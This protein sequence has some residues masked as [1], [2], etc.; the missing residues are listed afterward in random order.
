[1]RMEHRCIHRPSGRK[2]WNSQ[3]SGWFWLAKL[4]SNPAPYTRWGITSPDFARIVCTGAYTQIVMQKPPKR[5][6]LSYTRRISCFMQKF[7]PSTFRV[8]VTSTGMKPPLPNPTQQN[9][10]SSGPVN[11]VRYQPSSININ[12]TPQKIKLSWCGM[13][14]SST[15]K[16]IALEAGFKP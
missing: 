6:L 3:I 7:K 11:Q 4:C 8:K 16:K 14:D 9:P 12:H 15:T 10:K 5:V 2:S 1:M 13:N